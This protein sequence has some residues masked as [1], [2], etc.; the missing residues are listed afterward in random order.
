MNKTESF[1][2]KRAI[3]H[4]SSGN[5]DIALAD[6]SRLVG[7]EAPKV[8]NRDIDFRRLLKTGNELT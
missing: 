3:Q 5:H 7:C 6:L 1:I 8:K 4:I 2:V